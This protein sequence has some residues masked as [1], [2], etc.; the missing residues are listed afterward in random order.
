MGGEGGSRRE[1]REGEEG[2]LHERAGSRMRLRVG[3]QGPSRSR[4][5]SGRG[6]TPSL[7]SES[8]STRVDPSPRPAQAPRV[9][10]P[11]RVPR[12]VR[13][14]RMQSLSI[15]PARLARF[16]RVV[17]GPL[18]N[19]VPSSPRAA[20]AGFRDPPPFCGRMT[21]GRRRGSIARRAGRLSAGSEPAPAPDRI[22]GGSRL[23]RNVLSTRT[24]STALTPPTA[25]TPST[26][27]ILRGP[28]RAR[29]PPKRQSPRM[30]RPRSR[31]GVR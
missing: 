10:A 15:Q 12:T 20:P 21:A 11:P 19:P 13:R 17:R 6:G 29:T 18:V 26:A 8:G 9:P 1:E 14:G 2:G 7:P 30:E 28:A 5:P 24:A 27:P 4:S 22:R 3:R 31:E 16:A 25:P 23:H